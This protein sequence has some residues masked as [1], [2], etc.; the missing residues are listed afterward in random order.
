VAGERSASLDEKSVKIMRL[1]RNNDEDRIQGEIIDLLKVAAIPN[2]LYYH[3]PNGGKRHIKT[4]I[5]M[6]ALGVKAGITDLV[7]VCPRGVSHFMEVKDFDGTLS[8][9][10]REFR[11]FCLMIGHPWAIVRSRDQAQDV[12][13]SWGLLR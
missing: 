6:K 12:L 4:G 3:V 8:K 9:E 7:F 11:D 1:A 10:Q 13:V 5:A 2:L